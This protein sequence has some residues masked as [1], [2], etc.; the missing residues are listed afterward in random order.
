MA[1]P[2]DP[3]DQGLQD[4]IDLYT[5]SREPVIVVYPPF[6]QIAYDAQRRAARPTTGEREAE[7]RGAL[8][9]RERVR[10]ELIVEVHRL[11]RKITDGYA[12]EDDDAASEALREFA[13]RLESKPI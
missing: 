7:Q 6:D 11:G 8:V 5:K 10:L 1:H 4:A 9:E 2:I 13:H 3:R 12:D